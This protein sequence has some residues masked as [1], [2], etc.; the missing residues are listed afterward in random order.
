MGCDGHPSVLSTIGHLD[1]H[2]YSFHR[3]FSMGLLQLNKVYKNGQDELHG[4]PVVALK[5]PSQCNDFEAAWY[6]SGWCHCLQRNDEHVDWFLACHWMILPSLN[7]S[8]PAMYWECMYIIF[9]IGL[10]LRLP[11]LIYFLRLHS[12]CHHL[13]HRPMGMIFGRWVCIGG[14]SGIFGKSGSKVKVGNPK[15]MHFLGRFWSQ[16]LCVGLF[17][18][19]EGQ[20]GYL[21]H[22]AN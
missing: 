1:D 2:H 16:G 9:R 20:V 7:W 22:H 15:N 19:R 18:T 5:N 3:F 11:I 6:C 14:R 17:R 21:W 10:Q 12:V 13:S 8:S 4:P